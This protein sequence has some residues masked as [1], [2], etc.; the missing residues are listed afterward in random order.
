L[1]AIECSEKRLNV[2][3]AG[4]DKMALAEQSKELGYTF[5]V[6]DVQNTAGL[7]A[8]F[9][10]GNVVL[11][12]AGPFQYTAKH[13]VEACIEAKTHYIDITGEYQVFEMLRN[14]DERARLAKI[15]VLPGSGFDVVP[16]DCLA[17]HLKKRLPAANHLQLAF[18]MSKGGLS[19]GTA[20]TMIEGLG[21]GSIVREDGRLKSI[22]LGSKAIEVTFGNYTTKAMNIPWGDVSTAWFSTGIPNI[23]VYMGAKPGLVRLAK[24]SNMLSWFF[25]IAF[26]KNMLRRKINQRPSGPS[27]DNREKG[28]SFLW[29]KASAP[30]GEIAISTI[31]TMSGYKL[32][33][34]ASVLIAQK[35]LKGNYKSGYQTPASAYG[36]DIIMELENTVRVDK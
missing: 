36:D 30:S 11:H 24:L 3:L 8:L 19:R 22:P 15:T 12:C 35:I 14:Y 13:V 1:I 6:V 28:K 34:K 29:G 7:I 23:E 31:E 18:A 25:K 2:I 27:S 4:R 10:K 16:S 5:E 26:V 17:M 9:K 20:L 33:A 21:N 32:T